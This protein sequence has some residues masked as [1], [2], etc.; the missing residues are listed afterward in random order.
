MDLLSS[1]MGG[2][3]SG[4]PL[5]GGME[6]LDTEGGCSTPTKELI[7]PT[8]VTYLTLIKFNPML[9]MKT[10][11]INPSHVSMVLCLYLIV[12]LN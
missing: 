4:A 7:L 10:K 5:H 8:L 3:D 1:T 2:F 6:D 12:M 9:N 11:L